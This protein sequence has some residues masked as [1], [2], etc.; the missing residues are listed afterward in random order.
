MFPLTVSPEGNLTTVSSVPIGEPPV[1]TKVGIVNYV[2]GK[3][4]YTVLNLEPDA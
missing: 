1:T 3:A 4:V 2:F